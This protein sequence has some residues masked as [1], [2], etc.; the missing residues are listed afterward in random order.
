MELTKKDQR[1]IRNLAAADVWKVTDHASGNAQLYWIAYYKEVVK[2]LQNKINNNIRRRITMN[3]YYYFVAT[4]HTDT[5]IS[6]YCGTWETSDDDFPLMYIRKR[7]AKQLNVP[8][9]RVV[10]TFYNEITETNYKAYNNE[11]QD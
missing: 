4:V 7:I 2:H 10:I 3:K 1:H 8:T 9:K 5:D 11:Q 6:L